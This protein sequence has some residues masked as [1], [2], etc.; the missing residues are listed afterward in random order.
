MDGRTVAVVVVVL[1]SGKS[2][3]GALQWS[4]EADRS[5]HTRQDLLTTQATHA[6][7]T[8]ALHR[9]QTRSCNTSRVRLPL[10]RCR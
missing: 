3:N 6:Q 1:L 10:C 2:K 5:V 4:R 8:C 9:H 7:P